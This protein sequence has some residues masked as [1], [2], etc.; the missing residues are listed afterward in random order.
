MELEIMKVATNRLKLLRHTAEEIRKK[1][2]NK[3][4]GALRITRRKGKT[5]LYHRLNSED[6]NG[7]YIPQSK[8]AFACELAQKS[9]LQE[10]LK[11]IEAEEALLMK[12]VDVCDG[13]TFEN[14]YGSLSPM[15]QKM[16]LPINES[17]EVFAE[18]WK[19]QPFNK[20]AFADDT[21]FYPTKRGEKVRSKSEYIIA[22]ELF[23][24]GVPYRYECR[25]LVRGLSIYPDFTVLNVARRKEFIWEHLGMLD[26][27]NYA[28]AA[29]TKLNTY[30]SG[31][32]FPGVNL[33][34]TVETSRTP[35]KVELVRSIIETFLLK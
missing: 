31:G 23:Y 6:R 27:P 26:D 35:I 17:D 1:Q 22:D 3:P 10:A 13:N 28:E 4:D 24:A 15:R 29:T 7:R 18:R 30:M 14:V 34:L 20:K 33:L 2:K 19:G 11:S 16:S 12:Y 21:V 25:M 32:Y 9:Y 5:Q 8:Y